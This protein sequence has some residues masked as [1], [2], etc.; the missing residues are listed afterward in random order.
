M[1]FEGLTLLGGRLCLDF[2]N[3]AAYRATAQEQEFLKGG[4]ADLLDWCIYAGTLSE[5]ESTRLKGQAQD[6]PAQAQQTFRDVLKRRATLYSL[7]HHL[8]QAEAIPPE[9][10]QELNA[11]QQHAMSR[12]QLIR[13]PDGTF[14]WTWLP[15]TALSDVLDPIVASASELLVEGDLSRVRQC[16]GCG[17]LFY[18]SSRNRSRTWCDMQFCGN[19]AKARRHLAKIRTQTT[20]SAN[21]GPGKA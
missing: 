10:L 7:F 6:H 12:R 15:C 16:P 13:Q 20:P 11:A 18:D 8:A 14:T 17:W 1:G 4:Y 19:R 2:C 5:P 9:F 21:T 3:T